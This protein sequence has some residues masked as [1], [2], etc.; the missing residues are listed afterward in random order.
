VPH[1]SLDDCIR[2]NFTQASAED[3]PQ[4]VKRKVRNLCSFSVARQAV[5]TVEIGRSGQIGL[6]NRNGLFE[7]CSFFYACNT[8][9]AYSESGTGSDEP[10]VF[11][12]LPRRISLLE[13]STWSQRNENPSLYVRPP[14]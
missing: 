4:R 8:S 12:S 6:G 9:Q 14:V 3:V 10:G 2:R 7:A 11:T 13:K 1:C 5:L